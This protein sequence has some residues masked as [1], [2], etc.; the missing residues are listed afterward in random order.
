[1]KAGVSLF[2]VL[3][4]AGVA[5]GLARDLYSR[6]RGTLQGVVVG[7]DPG[8]TEYKSAITRT[9]RYKVRLADDRVVDVATRD[10]R[11]F[12]VGSAIVICELVTPWGQVWYKTR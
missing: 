8:G 10:A 4:L 1:M 9:P 6:E 12:P 7:A 2:L 11:K 5:I 3:L